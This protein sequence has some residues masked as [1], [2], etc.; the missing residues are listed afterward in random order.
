MVAILIVDESEVLAAS[1]QQLP[2]L[3]RMFSC[4]AFFLLYGIRSRAAC[5]LVCLMMDGGGKRYIVV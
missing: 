2:S 3:I 1:G 5:L 4:F